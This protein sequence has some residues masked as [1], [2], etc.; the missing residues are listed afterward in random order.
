VNPLVIVIS[1][2]EVDVFGFLILVHI[3]GGAVQVPSHL[4]FL[5]VIEVKLHYVLL[6]LS[7]EIG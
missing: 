4:F 5:D 1:R 3:W 7:L 2:V 6:V